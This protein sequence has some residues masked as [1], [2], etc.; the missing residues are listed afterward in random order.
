M[1][2]ACGDDMDIGV[3]RRWTTCGRA[4]AMAVMIGSASG[5]ALAQTTSAAGIAGVVRD[6]GTGEL[7]PGAKVTILGS[8]AETSTDRD[9]AFL[10]G[11]VASGPQ[12]V[13]VSY[14]GR[15][16]AHVDVDLT[17]GIVR[18]MEIELKMVGFEESRSR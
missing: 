15:T 5:A 2:S 7:L 4:A 17:A 10:L 6:A 16:D 13:V 18:R 11:N 14:L 9:G 8:A 12:T 1:E 3:V